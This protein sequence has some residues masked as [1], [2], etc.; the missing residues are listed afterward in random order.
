[1]QKVNSQIA[2]IWVM[3]RRLVYPAKWWINYQHSKAVIGCLNVKQKYHGMLQV[4][5]VLW[6]LRSPVSWGFCWFPNIINGTI[7]FARNIQLVLSWFWQRCWSRMRDTTMNLYILYDQVDGFLLLL[8]HN[9]ALW[10]RKN[11]NNHGNYGV[12]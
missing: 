9:I 12:S 8:D 2:Y 1:M 5:W 4:G 11:R 6:P 10:M 7:W 3:G